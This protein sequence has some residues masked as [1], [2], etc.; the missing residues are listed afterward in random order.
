MSNLWKRLADVAKATAHEA[1]DRLEDP[2]MMLNHYIREMEEELDDAQEAL[3]SQRAVE[4]TALL[5]HQEYLRIAAE[6]ETRASEALAAGREAEAR[7]ALVESWPSSRR[8]CNI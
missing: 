7:A 4:R 1:L 5:R 2:V 3:L 6:L 8:R